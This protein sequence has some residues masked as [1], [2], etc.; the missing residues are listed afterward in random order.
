MLHHAADKE[1]ALRA[2]AGLVAPGGRLLLVAHRKDPW[3]S[4]S[5]AS[6]GYLSI[7]TRRWARSAMR[8]TPIVRRP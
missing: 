3:S 4:I 5:R 1:A 8:S 6:A 7:R 2:L